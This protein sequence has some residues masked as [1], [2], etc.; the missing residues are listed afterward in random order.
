MQ[1]LAGADLLH[2]DCMSKLLQRTPTQPWSTWV[3]QTMD[4]PMTFLNQA[5]EAGSHPPV[6]LRPARDPLRSDVRSKDLLRRIG[7]PG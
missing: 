2:S 3:S 4:E 5:H 7:I 6:L 1:L